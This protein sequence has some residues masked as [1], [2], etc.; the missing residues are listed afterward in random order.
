MLRQSVSGLSRRRSLALS[1]FIHKE[2]KI[3]VY[4]C[5]SL[6]WLLKF[7]YVWYPSKIPYLT[8]ATGGL[9]WNNNLKRA[10]NRQKWVVYGCC[11]SCSTGSAGGLQSSC[12]V[13]G[14]GCVTPNHPWRERRYSWMFCD[15]FVIVNYETHSNASDLWCD[16]TDVCQ[17]IVEYDLWISNQRYHSEA[18][19]KLNKWQDG[20]Q[21]NEEGIVPNEENVG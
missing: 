2:Y 19:E 12:A 10:L 14:P 11:K 7:T 6:T 18:I 8:M 21:E 4:I 15:Y 1:W 5:T 9:D 3:L 16:N 20:Q 17:L 13:V